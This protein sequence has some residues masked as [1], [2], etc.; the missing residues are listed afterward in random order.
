MTHAILYSG[1]LHCS[2]NPVESRLN[3]SESHELHEVNQSQRRFADFRSPQPETST[4]ALSQNERSFVY[5]SADDNVLTC[6]PAKYQDC[7]A[8]TAARTAD[9]R[10]SGAACV[11]H[12]TRLPCLQVPRNGNVPPQYSPAGGQLQLGVR[13]HDSL[14]R[15]TGRRRGCCCVYLRRDQQSNV[16]AEAGA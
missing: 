5:F 14:Q 1:C 9:S 4:E 13:R 15:L 16:T 8:D 3:D 10:D 7:S 12:A 11:K 2:P 6:R